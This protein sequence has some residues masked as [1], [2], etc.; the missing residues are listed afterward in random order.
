MGMVFLSQSQIVAEYIL[1]R[2]LKKWEQGYSRFM[3]TGTYEDAGNYLLLDE[4]PKADYSH[5]GSYFIGS[6][7]MLHATKLWELSP[8][9][10]KLIH[11]YAINSA[12]VEEQYQW[13]RYLV[14]QEGLLAAG[15]N[16]TR[17]IIGLNAFDT[18][19][20]R[21]GS[22][23]ELYVDKLF[24]RHGLYSY[25]SV[26]GISKTDMDGF[27]RTI[28]LSR[29]RAQNVI[30]AMWSHLDFP[31]TDVGKPT[32][33]VKSY[34]ESI[35]TKDKAGLFA[36]DLDY[37]TPIF[38]EMLNYLSSR[39]VE[40][41]GVL[42][43]MHSWSLAFPFEKK[44]QERVVALFSSK[45]FK[46]VDLTNLLEDDDFFDSGH[47]NIKGQTKLNKVLTALAI[48]HIDSL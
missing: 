42:M 38:V 36:E 43:P 34:V 7:T 2:Q 32:F 31:S 45:G 8:S 4:I 16:K 47:A 24:S 27:E 26:K 21:P 20:K 23:D 14:E 29:M 3:Y 12:N 19:I 18:R 28:A 22:T 10:Q 5:G 46:V 13:I 48:E 39:N 9:K 25:D 1:Q 30:L 15:G 33:D 37:S 44:F 41:I 17:I 11:N 35:Q 40:V 6:S